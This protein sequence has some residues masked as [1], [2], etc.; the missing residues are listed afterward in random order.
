MMNQ[1]HSNANISSNNV[2]KNDNICVRENNSVSKSFAR[3]LREESGND[4]TFPRRRPAN[5]ENSL[6]DERSVL[7]ISVTL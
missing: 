2:P 6:Q 7:Q 5:S 3:T 1:N 4:N